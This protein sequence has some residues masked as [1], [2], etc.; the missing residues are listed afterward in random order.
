MMPVMVYLPAKGKVS[1][2]HGDALL[3][4]LA[5]GTVLTAAAARTQV[6]VFSHY[7]HLVEVAR[8]AIG[9]DGFRLHR[10]E[11]VALATAA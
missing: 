10:I 1:G 4:R 2:A 6:I 9:T 11:A 5:V 3:V 8:R 7:H